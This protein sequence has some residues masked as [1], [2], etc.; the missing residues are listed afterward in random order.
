[1][2]RASLKARRPSAPLPAIEGVSSRELKVDTREGAVRV[3]FSEPADR[4]AKA[5]PAFIDIHGGGF[6]LGSADGDDYYCRAICAHVGCV[7]VNVDYSL[8]PQAPFPAALRECYDIASWLSASGSELGVDPRRI[9]IGGHSAGGNLSAAVCLMAK[10]S[11]APAFVLQVLDYPPMDLAKD[12]YSKKRYPEGSKIIPPK[13]AKLF[14]K[15]YVTPEQ[16]LDPLASPVY[17]KDLSGLPPALVITAEEDSLAEEGE[18]YADML[19][20]AGVPVAR[21][22]FDKVPHAFNFKDCPEARESWALIESELS[23]AFA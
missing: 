4:R 6:I 21:K 10:A 9:A 11:G 19:A 2:Q 18:L 1:M 17:A 22:R 8:A 12:P 16:A 15:C 20:A 7:V 23:K 14:N 5:L 13:L 3:L